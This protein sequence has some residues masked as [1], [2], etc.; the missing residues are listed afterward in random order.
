[1][2]HGNKNSLNIQVLWGGKMRRG[3]TGL[4]PLRHL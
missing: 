4:W 1:M 2:T 3:V